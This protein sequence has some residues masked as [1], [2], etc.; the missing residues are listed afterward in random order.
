[1]PLGNCDARKIGNSSHMEPVAEECE[2]HATSIGAPVKQDA[3]ALSGNTALFSTSNVQRFGEFLLPQSSTYVRCL[4][5]KPDGYQ[6]L[7]V[8]YRKCPAD[9]TWSCHSH[10]ESNARACKPS[11]VWYRRCQHPASTGLQCR[12]KESTTS[13][14]EA[15]RPW[16]CNRHKHLEP[17]SHGERIATIL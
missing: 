16:S 5:V 15:K 7:R 13:K 3:L 4:G 2:H 12:N 10:P 1:M 9:D 6:C 8:V 11:F 17:Q 14:T